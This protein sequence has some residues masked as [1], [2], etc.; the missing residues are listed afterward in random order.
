MIDLFKDNRE[1]VRAYE[2]N[3][4]KRLNGLRNGK[5]DK[6][7][8][9]TVKIILNKNKVIF[10]KNQMIKFREFFKIR[11]SHVFLLFFEQKFVCFY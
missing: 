4:L 9:P 7:R 11:N 10:N 8:S 1:S 6:F 5:V 3:Q 2:I